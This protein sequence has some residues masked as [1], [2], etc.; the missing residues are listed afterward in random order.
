MRR[1]AFVAA[2]L[3]FVACGGGTTEPAVSGPLVGGWDAD[4]EAL[5]PAGTMQ[6]TLLFLSNGRF[7]ATVRSFGV[8]AGQAAGDV[9]SV[10]RTTGSYRASS[11]GA[12]SFAPDSLVTYDRFYGP[13]ARASV[14]TPYPYPPGPFAG[15]HFE[16][17]D[18]QLTIHYTTYPADAPVPATAVYRRVVT[19]Q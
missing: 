2:V 8:Y 4:V 12:L 14:Q 11:D 1:H 18:R 17:T 16:V 19:A 15:A 9:S 3:S 5:H 10:I 6:N 7:V 13:N